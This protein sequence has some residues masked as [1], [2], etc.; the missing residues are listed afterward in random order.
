MAGVPD[1]LL[2]NGVV[3]WCLQKVGS[4]ETG[5]DVEI[6]KSSESNVNRLFSM[7]KDESMN[8]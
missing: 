3:F 1:Q 4:C 2:A 7:F 8:W 5:F 6:F